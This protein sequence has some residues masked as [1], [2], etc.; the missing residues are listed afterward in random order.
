MIVFTILG[1]VMLLETELAL[2]WSTLMGSFS[3]T[4]DGLK[5]HFDFV[6]GILTR[7]IP[8]ALTVVTVILTVTL[9]GRRSQPLPAELTGETV[10]ASS[11]DAAC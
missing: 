11:P 5:F 10:P 7:L 6:P 8:I 2:A 4:G 1:T 9:V 3:Y